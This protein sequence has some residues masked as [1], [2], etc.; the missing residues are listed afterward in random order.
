[1]NAVKTKNNQTPKSVIKK[2]LE[3]QIEVA[4]KDKTSIGKTYLGVVNHNVSKKI[5]RLTGIN[6]E[7]KNH[8]IFDY[9]IRHIIKEHGNSVIEKQ[10]G[11]LPITK[12]DIKQIPNVI[13]N[14]TKIIK[15]TNNRNKK[16]IRYI[17]NYNNHIIIIVEIIQDKSKN[18]VIKTMW[19]KP[20]ALI[21][22]N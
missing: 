5:K 20:F 9:D 3:K 14:P 22:G 21:N 16:T 18:L 12:D 10:K 2:R 17:K 13:N 19:K 8:I 7:G 6:V 15:G 11:Q 4:L 1:M